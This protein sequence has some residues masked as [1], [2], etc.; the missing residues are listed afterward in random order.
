MSMYLYAYVQCINELGANAVCVHKCHT[1]TWHVVKC[2]DDVHGQNIY[3]WS[4]LTTAHDG[5]I[6]PLHTVD[7][8]QEVLLYCNPTK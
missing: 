6:Q 3:F 2:H 7:Y 8:S 4:H 1:H 5:E